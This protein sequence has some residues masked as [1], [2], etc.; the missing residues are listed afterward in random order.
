MK[1]LLFAVAFVFAANVAVAQ[2]PA[3]KADAKKLLQLS[4]ANSQME[5][6]KKQVSGMVPAAKKDAFL[7]DFD[8]LLKPYFEK[9]EQFYLTEFTADELKQLVKFYESPLGK[10]LTEKNLK[11]SEQNMADSQETMVKMQEIMMKYMQ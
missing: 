7:K 4:G 2:A 8:E 6:A 10:K 11:L 1:K 3:A 9:Q 5:M